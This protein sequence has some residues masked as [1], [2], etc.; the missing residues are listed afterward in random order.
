MMNYQYLKFLNL[1]YWY[2][3]IYSLFGGRCTET[4]LG[5]PSVDVNA[6]ITA[7]GTTATTTTAVTAAH[8]T[9]HWWSSLVEGGSAVG[10]AI[11]A[12]LS[13]LWGIYSAIAYTVSGVLALSIIGSATGLIL[14]RMRELATY[15]TLPQAPVAAHTLRNRW[16]SLLDNAMST[17]P[18][19]WREGIL[20]ADV[21]LGELLGTLG[22]K[23]ASTAEQMQQVPE[24]AFVTISEA[25]EAHRIRNFVSMRSSDYI[26]TQ[27]EAFRVMKLYEQVFEE[28]DFV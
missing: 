5:I 4:Q 6:Q 22:Y 14:L 28:F 7:G 18:K 25:W 24:S 23:G 13:L 2:C 17:D 11:L 27:R 3:I 10:T 1:Q 19:R 9:A 12:F 20:D 15:S 16:Q 8:Q 21:M 26:L